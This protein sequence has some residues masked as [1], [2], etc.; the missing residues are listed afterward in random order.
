[1]IVY[2]I[3]AHGYGHAIRACEVIRHL[4]PDLPLT[5]RTGNPEWLLRVEL[6]G[7][8]APILPARFD[9]GT[10]GPDATS[11][12]LERT[13]DAAEAIMAANDARLA[14][15]L[16]LLESL[17]ARIIVSDAAGFPLRAA[18][19]AGIHSVLVANFT[20]PAIYEALLQRERPAP[21][22][23]RRFRRTIDRMQAEYD[24]GELFLVPGLDIPM[25]A[26][27]ERREI[28]LIARR[29]RPRRAELAGALGLDEKRPIWLL[30]LGAEGR[31]GMQW[32]RLARLGDG[33]GPLQIVAYRPP[34]GAEAFVRP[35]PESF[36]HADAVASVDAAIAKPGY[37]TASECMAAGTP[38]FYTTRPQFAEAAAIDRDLQ[39]WGGALCIPEDDFL[40]LLWSP[41]LD[42]LPELRAVVHRVDGSGGMAAAAEIERLWRGPSGARAD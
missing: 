42:R 16:D 31:A 10:L 27:R 41:W 12:D 32:E 17:G 2:Y 30:Y 19:E 7:R 21:P 20:W 8:P 11:V 38:L 40:S 37:G 34:A 33:A 1:M 23:A 35:I 28:P 29:G 3:T 15:E 24:Q 6:G 18:R 9:C 4:S 39:A 22:L 14:A 5:L 13:A 25:R 36:E 26:C